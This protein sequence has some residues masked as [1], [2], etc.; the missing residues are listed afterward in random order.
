[1]NAPIGRR[2][3]YRRLGAGSGAR[4]APTAC[5]AVALLV[6]GCAERRGPEAG[7][8]AVRERIECYSAAHR[9]ALESADTAWSDASGAARG[10][11]GSAWPGGSSGAG[12]FRSF[13]RTAAGDGFDDTFLALGTFA[14]D[15]APQT[16]PAVGGAATQSSSQ[17]AAVR[18]EYWRPTFAR[19][20]GR[21]G[22]DFLK[23]DFWQ[24]WRNSFWDV[25]N[26]IF[27]T[28][29]L[30]ASIAIRESGVDD[31]IRERVRGHQQFGDLDETVQIIGNPGTHFAAAGAAWLGTAIFKDTQGHEFSRSLTQ[32]LIVNGVTTWVLK[33]AADTRAPDNV[34]EAWPSGHTSSVFTVA[35]VANEYYGPWVGIPSFAL[36]GL[37]GYQRLDSQVHDFSDV[38]FGAVLGYVVGT[39]VARGN[40]AEFPKLFG[41]DLV[42]Y[43]DPQTGALGLGLMKTW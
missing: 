16:R 36:A 34:D 37:V 20:M 14:N 41:M 15:D 28:T 8:W 31:T 26:A 33:V 10:A 21:E 35:A 5:L 3:G 2:R 25:K 19:Q 7:E 39:S 17:P 22:V 6:S 40:Q 12:L 18:K 43:Q 24:G 30:G 4:A 9:D 38:V 32:A 23:R 11:A 27:L 42:P 13:G 29:A 1:M